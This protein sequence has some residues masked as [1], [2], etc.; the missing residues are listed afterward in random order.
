[1]IKRTVAKSDAVMPLCEHL[2]RMMAEAITNVCM[3]EL[4]MLPPVQIDFKKQVSEESQVP[5]TQTKVWKLAERT[6]LAPAEK[7]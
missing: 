4:S 1:M 5:A 7:A 6:E 2:A 3:G